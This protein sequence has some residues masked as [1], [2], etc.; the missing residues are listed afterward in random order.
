[1]VG[2][3]WIFRP[4]IIMV[5]TKTNPNAPVRNAMQLISQRIFVF[6]VNVTEKFQAH[7]SFQNENGPLSDDNGRQIQL[8]ANCQCT[9]DDADCLQNGWHTNQ[10]QA[11]DQG[12]HCSVHGLG[13][14]ASSGGD[15]TIQAPD[16][17]TD[18][19]QSADPE[20]YAKHQTL[21]VYIRHTG[22][23][24]VVGINVQCK[25]IQ[26]PR[27]LQKLPCSSETTQRTESADLPFLFLQLRS[28]FLQL[29]RRLQYRIYSFFGSSFLLFV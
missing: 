11:T 22:L 27:M 8:Y 6:F 12:V 5:A 7:L 16:K 14:S 15:V 17:H 13:I 24:G 10:C 2:I 19:D 9:L 3:L 1:M 18:T 26:S 25:C 23:Y 29:Q 28:R 4:Q 20:R 21:W